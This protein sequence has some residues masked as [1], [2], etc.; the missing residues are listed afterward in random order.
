MLYY[1]E[2]FMNNKILS[3]FWGF[4]SLCVFSLLFSCS[5]SAQENSVDSDTP[6]LRYTAE[7]LYK[8]TVW[9]E[10]V[11]PDRLTANVSSANGISSRITLSPL[12]VLAGKT[13]DSERLYPVLGGFGSLDTSLISPA[14]REMLTLFS[15][16]ISKNKDADSFM[17]Q[18]CVYSLALFY[19]DFNKIFSDCFELD[20]KAKTDS[21]KKSDSE[22][23]EKDVEEPPLFDSFVFGQPFLDGLYY[24]VP[25]K[26]F[27][28]K[29]TLTLCVF[30]VEKSGSW[31]VDQVQIA[32]WE[33]LDGKK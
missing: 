16:S 11:E 18:E 9:T 21:E 5:N 12:V 25:V 24:E 28:K 19:N 17:V 6:T 2:T 14:L 7:S 32:D 8:S 23:S 13:S 31:K 27:S 15:D 30:C 22:K 10:E 3:V 33:I 26:F 20:K 4:V 1:I 29:A